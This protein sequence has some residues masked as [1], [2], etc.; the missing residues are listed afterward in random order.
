MNISHEFRTTL[1]LILGPL[2]DALASA[3]LH[4]SIRPNLG[5]VQKN[6]LRLLRLINQLMDF[7]KIEENKM[8]LVVSENNITD[9]ITESGNAFR[10]IARRKSISFNIISSEK[11]LRVWF[12]SNILDKVF[13]NL[14]S[15]AFK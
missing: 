9:F 3:K 11:H 14:L 15:N 7:R 6:A 1:T 8:K 13:F 12:D 2:E 10:E 5:L 4:F